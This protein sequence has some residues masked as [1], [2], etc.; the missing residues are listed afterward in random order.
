MRTK[1][2][3]LLALALGCGVV[4]AV[5]ITQVMAT[6]HPEGPAQIELQSIVVAMKDVPMGD[7]VPPELVSLEDWPKDKVPKGAITKIEDVEN[8]RP[9]AR[10]FAGSPILE[11]QLLGKGVLDQGA[12]D[13]IPKGLRVIAVK[14]NEVSGSASLI[15]PGDRVDVLVFLQRGGDMGQTLTKTIL[16]DVKVFAVDNSWE[17]ATGGEKSVVARTISLLVTPPQAEQ[18]TLAC[19]MGQV[20]LVM[21]SPDDKEQ[22]KVDGTRASDVLLGAGGGT[23]RSL[24]SAATVGSS[25]SKSNAMAGLL[26]L[27][28]SQKD[29]KALLRSVQSAASRAPAK[30]ADVF[31]VRVLAGSQATDTVLEATGDAKSAAVSDT[32]FLHWRQSTSSPDASPSPSA[33]SP[34]ASPPTTTEAAATKASEAPPAGA[35]SP[36]HGGEA[37]PAKPKKTKSVDD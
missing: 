14:V 22:V 36:D 13:S 33:S 10:I 23:D 12:S 15:R 7:P 27:L 5:G 21:R 20:R 25:Q 30:S 19:E 37:T 35:P 31:T 4:A 32:S 9:K 17:A 6:R 11:S 34:D 28:N 16:Q 24:W 3:I 26:G 1:S 8:R 29:Q 18:V 2:I